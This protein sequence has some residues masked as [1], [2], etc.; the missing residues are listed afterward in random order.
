MHT[1]TYKYTVLFLILLV[2]CRKDVTLKLPEYKQ[3]VV[4]EAS[5]ETGSTASVFLS[6]SVPYFGN[7][8][9]TAP[10]KAFI[11]GAFVTVTDGTTIDTLKELDPNKGYLYF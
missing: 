4:I 1:P 2:S 5:I 3:K 11:K 6:Y 9:Y 8:D 7:F 10:E